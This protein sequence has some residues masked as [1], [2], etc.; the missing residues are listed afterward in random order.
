[1]EQHK[2]NHFKEGKGNFMEINCRSKSRH[3]KTDSYLCFHQQLGR[4]RR[5]SRSLISSVF[6]KDVIVTVSQDG[7]KRE[8]CNV[9]KTLDTLEDYNLDELYY[10]VD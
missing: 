10:A 5:D 6:G 8:G 4:G 9:T 3:S 2:Q 1:M 7:N